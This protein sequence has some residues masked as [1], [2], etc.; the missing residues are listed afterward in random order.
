MY[1]KNYFVI[2]NY[3][4]D[5]FIGRGVNI[6]WIVYVVFLWIW[7]SF[8]WILVLRLMK[9]LNKKKSEKE[10]KGLKRFFFKLDFGIGF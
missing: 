6:L 4:V 7:K 9:I 10:L 3:W 5:I 2:N 1:F 8:F